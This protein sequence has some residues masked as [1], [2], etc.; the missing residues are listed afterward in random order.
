MEL[1]GTARCCRARSTG[2][3]RGAR[4]GR[5]PCRMAS[6]RL[7]PTAVVGSPATSCRRRSGRSMARL[8]IVESPK[9]EGSSQVKFTT[10]RGRP[11][12]RATTCLVEAPRHLEPR[13]GHAGDPVEPSAPASD[14]CRD[15]SHVMIEGP[16]CRHRPARRLHVAPAAIAPSPRVPAARIPRSRPRRPARRG[17]SSETRR[18]P[19]VYGD[20]GPRIIVAPAPSTSAM[21]AARR[22]G[23]GRSGESALMPS[24]ARAQAAGH[25][26]Q[27]R[28]RRSRAAYTW[29][30]ASSS[31]SSMYSSALCARSMSPGPRMTA[32]APRPR[33]CV[34]SQP[35]P[36]P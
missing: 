30:P 15:G 16:S 20:V 7:L 6:P 34:M 3:R 17:P 36:A 23:C 28:S 25:G 31:A 32:S 1:P 4:R 33:K 22:S 9:S 27:A 11:S 19:C 12:R 35:K 14:A 21:R 8:P 2:P 26:G 24:R 18:P 29:R 13:P 10:S 5:P